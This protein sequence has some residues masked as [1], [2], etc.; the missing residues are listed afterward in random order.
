MVCVKMC[1]KE[2]LVLTFVLIWET[3]VAAQQKQTSP[4]AKVEDFG[5]T[6]PRVHTSN[7]CERCLAL[8]NQL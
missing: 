5:G 8:A 2:L 3:P 6:L 4:E 1:L 7:P